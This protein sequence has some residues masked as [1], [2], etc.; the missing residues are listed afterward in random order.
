MTRSPLVLSR[1]AGAWD[2]DQ[3]LYDSTLGWRFVNPAMQ[4][5]FGIDS[6]PETAENLARERGITREDQDAYA[7][8]SQQRAARA[9]AEGRLAAELLPVDV[10]TASGTT[11]VDADEH[12]R[13]ATT[14]EA[15][16]RLKPILGPGT[17]ITAGNSS[18]IN[19]GAGAVLLA[20]EAAVN[21][22]R[23]QPIARIAGMASAGVPPRTMG[24][25]PVPAIR[26]L[27]GG[28]WMR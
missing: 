14:L 26:K 22:H 28:A 21:R 2:R 3:R 18:G 24:M 16:A 5:R 19:D 7:C 1:A 11:R 10:K 15:L 8:R 23:L 4:E 20:S 27:P 13:P 6:M 25:G 12:P 17:T 9:Q